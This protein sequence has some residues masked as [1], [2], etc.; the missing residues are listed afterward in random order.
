MKFLPNLRPLSLLAALLPAA[1][2]ADTY[3]EYSAGWTASRGILSIGQVRDLNYFGL[4]LSKEI[5]Y[6]KRGF[7]AGPNLSF[8]RRLME[9]STPF[10]GVQYAPIYASEDTY[11]HGQ[12]YDEGLNGGLASGSLGYQFEYK[13]LGIQVEISSDTPVNSEFGKEWRFRWGLGLSFLSK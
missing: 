11:F 12:A 3:L 7:L 5:T 4:G 13:K 1:A 2:S 10:L 9:R 8:E 6:G